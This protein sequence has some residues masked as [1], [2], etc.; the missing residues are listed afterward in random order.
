MHVSG[1]IPFQSFLFQAFIYWSIHSY[2][3]IQLA[4]LSTNNLVAC[5]KR[6]TSPVSIMSFNIVQYEVNP[7]LAALHFFIYLE[8]YVYWC[9]FNLFL[10]KTIVGTL[11]KKEIVIFIFY[12]TVGK[13]IDLQFALKI[14][15]RQ[16]NL[17]FLMQTWQWHRTLISFSC[18][19]TGKKKHSRLVFDK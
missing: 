1:C 11:G 15:K 8:N 7:A 13:I 9:C 10:Y 18:L 17:K 6:C 4:C 5:W 14:I 19:E 12:Q 16:V 3:V 2:A